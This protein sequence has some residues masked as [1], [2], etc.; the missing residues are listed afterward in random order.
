MN[1]I[2]NKKEWMADAFRQATPTARKWAMAQMK[3]GASYEDIEEKFLD[4]LFIE[5]KL[6]EKMKASLVEH[7]RR[8]GLNLEALQF[9]EEFKRVRF[10]NKNVYNQIL[11]KIRRAYVQHN[12]EDRNLEYLITKIN[13]YL[14]KVAELGKTA[15]QMLMDGKEPDLEAWSNKAVLN[16]NLFEE[17]KQFLKQALHHLAVL[18]KNNCKLGIEDIKMLLYHKQGIRREKLYWQVEDWMIK[19]Y[20]GLT[21]DEDRRCAYKEIC[22]FIA[23]TVPQV[24]YMSPKMIRF[25]FDK[26]Y[27]SKTS[28]DLLLAIK[29]VICR[30]G[31]SALIIFPLKKLY[32]QS[33]ANSTD[34]EKIKS[35]QFVLEL[36]KVYCPKE[37]K[38]LSS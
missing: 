36:M 21:T 6:C 1:L 26:G 23:E 32:Q 14:Q 11:K 8:H 4:I 24:G 25:I 13:E 5:D 10:F 33:S 15:Y 29:P 35:D 22:L 16:D 12:E 30:L 34:E 18:E 28:R 37:L 19:I 9:F 2:V 20:R 27:L 31:M 38:G 3:K 7:I 17:N